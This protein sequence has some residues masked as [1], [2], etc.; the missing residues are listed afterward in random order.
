MGARNEKKNILVYR[1]AQGGGAG[2]VRLQNK[3]APLPILLL[4]SGAPETQKIFWCA[5]SAK[6]ILV[7]LVYLCSRPAQGGGAGLERWGFWHSY[8]QNKTV[9]EPPL[10]ILLWFTV[11][12]DENLCISCMFLFTNMHVKSGPCGAMDRS[13]VLC[14]INIY[15]HCNCLG[16]IS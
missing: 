13:F 2:L 12:P 4:A 3:T 11:G 16:T 14:V 6:N 10:P 5:R 1:P 15:V 7:I 9:P 8:H